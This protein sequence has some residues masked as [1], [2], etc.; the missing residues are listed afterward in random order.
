MDVLEPP[1]PWADDYQKAVPHGKS[2]WQPPTDEAYGLGSQWFDMSTTP[3]QSPF[4]QDDFVGDPLHPGAD[5]NCRDAWG[6]TPRHHYYISTLDKNYT[7]LD[8]A[9]EGDDDY[10]ADLL[11]SGA[12]VNCRDVWGQT[13]LHHAVN[14]GGLESVRV[15]LSQPGVSTK[16]RD[17]MNE[18]ALDLARKQVCPAIV[19][20]LEEFDACIPLDIVAPS[21]KPKRQSFILDVLWL[22][23][24]S[25]EQSDLSSTKHRDA[26]SSG[27]SASDDRVD[28][29][30][31]TFSRT[32]FTS[33]LEEEYSFSSLFGTLLRV[34]RRKAELANVRKRR[35][36]VTYDNSEYLTGIPEVSANS[37]ELDEGF[38]KSDL[39][40]GRP[41]PTWPPRRRELED[42][43]KR[44]DD[45]SGDVQFESTSENDGT[46]WDR[47][48]D[49]CCGPNA[50]LRY[51]NGDAG[52]RRRAPDADRDATNVERHVSTSPTK[53]LGTDF[54]GEPH[55]VSRHDNDPSFDPDQRHHIS[56]LSTPGRTS[57]P[58]GTESDGPGD[59][60]LLNIL[61][62]LAR[63]NAGMI[64]CSQQPS[65]E[66]DSCE[67][68]LRTSVARRS[69]GSD[70]ILTSSGSLAATAIF[71][72]ARKDLESLR[73]CIEDLEG[74]FD[75]SADSSQDESGRFVNS[76]QWL[77]TDVAQDEGAT[78][79][80]N[81]E[82]VTEGGGEHHSSY[83]DTSASQRSGAP[84]STDDARARKRPR[85]DDTSKDHVRADTA[86]DHKRTKLLD[87]RFICCFHD[88]P[89]QKCFGT[90]E[91]ISEVIKRLA[92]QHNTHVCDRCWSLKEE[93]EDSDLVHGVTCRDYCLSP[94]CHDTSRT[95]GHRHEFD[96]RSCGRKT[97]RVRPGDSEAIYRFIYYLIHAGLDAP[98]EVYTPKRSSHL[99]SVPR[100][101]RRKATREELMARADDLETKLRQGENQNAANVARIEGLEQDFEKQA[102]LICELEKQKRRIIV[103]LSDALRTGKFPDHAGHAS[104]RERVREDAP[105]ALSYE[106]H[107]VLTPTRSNDSQGSGPSP[108]QEDSG[109]PGYPHRIQ[110][111]RR[112]SS[113]QGAPL[114]PSSSG[115]FDRSPPHERK[116]IHASRLHLAPVTHLPDD[117]LCSHEP[118]VDPSLSRQFVQQQDTNASLMSPRAPPQEWY[119]FDHDF[120][121]TDGSDTV[122]YN[123][124]LLDG[125]D[126]QRTVAKQYVFGA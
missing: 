117:Y 69:I 123:E 33:F 24:L 61:P 29:C 63:S 64:T 62:Q 2:K 90:D 113:N 67:E 107:S 78:G 31:A 112:Q 72:E 77:G 65:S 118:T 8:A 125:V 58:D 15:L 1:A 122:A 10:I 84:S 75:D 46:T 36:S 98:A 100:Q 12:D 16:A 9:S 57:P 17:H 26:G 94:Q 124:F 111:I 74:N 3:P 60:L 115:D 86:L 82:T 48:I 53:A 92:E 38:I 21:P 89:G 27:N 11:Q 121:V 4:P 56:V 97:S 5:V 116:S 102:A 119:D 80:G 20:A 6:Q 120:D 103:M 45:L 105:D 18:T 101:G 81:Q 19:Q 40:D 104:L 23:A 39:S 99:G 25:R 91:T 30:G 96:Q 93:H 28:A 22:K 51:N 110:A 109:I 41:S 126:Q 76:R 35:E 79:S 55:L 37:P 34:R 50:R 95:V 13:P 44:A 54:T 32:P 7:L 42:L 114:Q 49:V 66:H 73:F 47:A 52:N 83:T 87:K 14:A 71:S 68:R 70:F 85:P 88:G 108:I 43:G 106:I 59:S